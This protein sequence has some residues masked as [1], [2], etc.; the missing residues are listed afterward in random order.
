MKYEIKGRVLA[1]GETKTYGQNGFEKREVV[2]DCAPPQA[3]WNNPLPFTL[4]KERCA[5]GDDIAEGDEVSITFAL[6]GRAWDGPN[7][8]RYFIDLSVL[9]IEKA[10]G[11][12]TGDGDATPYAKDAM[13]AWAAWCKH[14]DAKDAAGFTALLAQV[15][16]AVADVAKKAGKKFSQV[17]Q[18]DDW[19]AIIAAITGAGAAQEPEPDMNDPDNLPF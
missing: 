7:G 14:R 8:T 3:R 9:A 11:E 5:L 10:G 16:P 17:A 6:N 13:G 1:V 18:A 2:V 15:R 4:S 19:E 12:G